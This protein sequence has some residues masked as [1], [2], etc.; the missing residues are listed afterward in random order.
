MRLEEDG[1][2]ALHDAS[3]GRN[4]GPVALAVVATLNQSSFN[5]LESYLLGTP[6][7]VYE[8]LGHEFLRVSW[9]RFPPLQHLVLGLHF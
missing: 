4:A 8:R 7:D 3:G 1:V 2:L 6:L 9:F 5:R